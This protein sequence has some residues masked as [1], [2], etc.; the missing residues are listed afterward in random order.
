MGE[1]LISIAMNN[2]GEINLGLTV[3]VVDDDESFRKSVAR[4][5]TACGF[6]VKEYESARA[7]LNVKPEPGCIFL[8]V[9]MPGMSGLEL[10]S[11]LEEA[12]SK[13]PIVFLSGH[14]DVAD[15]V[16]A[17]RAGAEDF[18]TKPVRKVRL[19]EAITSALDRFRKNTEK[20]SKSAKLRALL[21]SLTLRERQ[22]FA[23]VTNG[24]MNKQIAHELSITERTIKAHRLKMMGKLHL[25]SF[26]D[27]IK[28]AEHV[29]ADVT[30][31]P[32]SLHSPTREQIRPLLT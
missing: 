26:A 3:H 15:S 30:S 31:P 24:K 12:G 5:L 10:Q 16:K 22:V 27:L 20:N 29:K 19:V 2:S 8:D 17:M 7:F 18:L 6:A 4:L 32:P 14:A 25:D 23:L 28:F 9:R 21:D 13:L 1:L 11:Q